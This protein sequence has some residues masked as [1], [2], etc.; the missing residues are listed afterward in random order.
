MSKVTLQQQ[1]EMGLL[2]ETPGS[3]V[4]P[5]PV[6]RGREIVAAP[7]AGPIAEMDVGASPGLLI[8]Q[9]KTSHVDR[10]KAFSIKTWQLSMV[11]LVILTLA[12]WLIGAA[13]VPALLTGLI[14]YLA[15]WLGAF[16]IDARNSPGGVARY[17]SEQQ[18]REIRRMNEARVDAFR[19]A[20]GLDRGRG[21]R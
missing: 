21:R 8:E 13:F 3:F 20:N 15:V 18:W 12:L 7:M 19:K 6:D 9:Y 4:P 1:R 5:A 17:H 11:T 14:A 2:R 10:A 16:V